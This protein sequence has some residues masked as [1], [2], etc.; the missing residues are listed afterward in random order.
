MQK[1]EQKKPKSSGNVKIPSKFSKKATNKEMLR[2][3]LER[4]EKQ[5]EKLDELKGEVS[6]IKQRFDIYVK[7][8]EKDKKKEEVAQKEKKEHSKWLWGTIISVAVLIGK[9]I[10]DLIPK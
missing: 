1:T 8:E 6:L 3:L 2:F 5:D 10:W 9:I 4:S 7:Q